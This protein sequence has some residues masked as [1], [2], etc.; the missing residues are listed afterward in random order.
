VPAAALASFVGLL[1]AAAVLLVADT[2]YEAGLIPIE[3]VELVARS[4]VTG[5]LVYVGVILLLFVEPPTRFFAVMEPVSPDRRPTWL[6]I[7]LGLGFLVVLLVP[8]LRNF[9]NL[10]PLSL[11]EVGIVAAGVAAWTALVWIFWRGRFVDRFLGTTPV[12]ALVGGN[13]SKDDATETEPEG[14]KAS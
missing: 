5:F 3:N 2:D 8:P 7:A 4:A 14:S 12:D 13:G 6:A 11:R 10:H 9:F 1:V